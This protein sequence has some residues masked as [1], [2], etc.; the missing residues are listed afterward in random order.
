VALLTFDKDEAKKINV[1]IGKRLVLLKRIQL[2]REE[3]EGSK[4]GNLEPEDDDES[5]PITPGN[6]LSRTGRVFFWGGRCEEFV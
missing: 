6:I 5:L 3:S 4:S 2:L 1:S